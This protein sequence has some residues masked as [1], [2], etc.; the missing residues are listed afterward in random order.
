MFRRCC[1][2]SSKIPFAEVPTFTEVLAA[3][4]AAALV[5][6]R[7]VTQKSS[8]QKFAYPAADQ[9]P[10]PACQKLLKQLKGIQQGLVE[11]EFGWLD[12][13]HSPSS[14]DFRVAQEDMN[15]VANGNGSVDRLP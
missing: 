10:G 1:A 6:I 8:N 9:E 15:G 11:D 2:N 5:P 12:P 3:G 14:Y 13:V 7:S 4:T